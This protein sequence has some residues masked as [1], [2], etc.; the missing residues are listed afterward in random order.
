MSDIAAQLEVASQKINLFGQHVQDRLGKAM[1]K[2][3]LKITAE[4]KRNAP[5]DTGHLAQSIT[6]TPIEKDGEGRLEIRG[7]P[8]VQYGALV[9]FGSGPHTSSEGTED[10]VAN[11]ERWGRRK[12][13]DESQIRALIQHIRKH[14]TKPHPYLGPAFY[15]LIKEIQA[16]ME[17]AIKSGDS[18]GG[19]S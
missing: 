16:D 9:E 1:V 5:K 11:I 2:G 18:S 19:E 17:E 14:G 8:T 4:A 12:G 3:M 6:Q 13:M 10:F 7:G 15:S